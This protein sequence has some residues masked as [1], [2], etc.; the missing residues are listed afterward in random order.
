M[1]REPSKLFCDAS[2]STLEKKKITLAVMTYTVLFSFFF[3]I[4]KGLTSRQIF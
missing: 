4:W 3:L 2:N 1:R